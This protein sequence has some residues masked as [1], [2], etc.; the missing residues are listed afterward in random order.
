MDLWK[1]G[2]SYGECDS[3]LW[4]GQYKEKLNGTGDNSSCYL[5]VMQGIN[6]TRQVLRDENG[7]I[8]EPLLADFLSHKKKNLLEGYLGSHVD[9]AFQNYYSKNLAFSAEIGNPTVHY[10]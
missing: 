8:K 10:Y 5:N 3:D 9:E 1:V 7:G 6:S 4:N 2:T